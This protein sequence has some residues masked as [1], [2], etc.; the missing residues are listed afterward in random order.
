M[1]SMIPN[2]PRNDHPN[3]TIKST[4]IFW[5]DLHSY[6][7]LQ[8]PSNFEFLII[9][10]LHMISTKRTNTRQIDQNQSTMDKTLVTITNCY[11][12]TITS[13]RIFFCCF[14]EVTDVWLNITN[15]NNAD[16]N[17]SFIIPDYTHFSIMCIYIHVLFFSYLNWCF[18]LKGRATSNLQLQNK[19]LLICY[20]RSCM[21]NSITILCWLWIW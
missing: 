20:C 15:L 5:D 10:V 18:F 21:I 8:Y 7:W 3:N 13:V 1:I 6:R 9:C 19:Q 17:S 2:A 12:S 4:Y 14:L 11:F 16:Q